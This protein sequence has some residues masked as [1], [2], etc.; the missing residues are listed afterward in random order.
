[1]QNIAL[2]E[3]PEYLAAETR[4]K[5][6]LL[7][8][9]QSHTDDSIEKRG[10]LEKETVTEFTGEKDE[11][12]ADVTEEIELKKITM[13]R[14]SFGE[15]TGEMDSV[16]VSDAVFKNELLEIQQRRVANEIWF[17]QY[18]AELNRAL[19]VVAEAEAALD[20]YESVMIEAQKV[21]AGL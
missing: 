21:A 6:I 2:S 4:K 14:E 12:G 19:R 10:T 18:R 3:L 20:A 16:D 8:T 1:M 5:E 17:N 7:K 11:K 13:E 15:K 9:I